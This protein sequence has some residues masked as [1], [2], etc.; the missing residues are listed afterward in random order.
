M[1]NTNSRRNA[2]IYN[3]KSNN[4]QEISM[5]TLL[6]I[7]C[8]AALMKWSGTSSSVWEIGEPY[9]RIYCSPI[10]HTDHIHGVIRVMASYE[11][12]RHTSN[13]VI[14]V[15]ASYESWRHTSHGVVRVM[16]SYE[17]WRHTSN[18]VI[19]VMASY[20][21]WRRTTHGVIRV[22]PS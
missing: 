10:S 21:S 7:H 20:E 6:P 17:S 3:E 13:G 12:W 11:S 19:R 15:M 16:A 5:R 8:L 14:R 1:C 22:M 18:G 4:A 2:M 9:M